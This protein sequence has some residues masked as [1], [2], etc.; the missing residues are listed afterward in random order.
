MLKLLQDEP[1]DVFHAMIFFEFTATQHA[2][3]VTI[4]KKTAS[5]LQEV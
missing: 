2:K 4:P 1:I 3:V 5:H